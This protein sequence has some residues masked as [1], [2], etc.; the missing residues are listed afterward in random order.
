VAPRLIFFGI[1]GG[2]WHIIDPLIEGGELPNLRLLKQEGAW[3]T[4]RSLEP[5]ISPA[6]WT[7]I[8]SGKVPAKHGVKDFVV[9]AQSVRCKRFWEIAEEN[10]LSVG[11]LGYLV[12]WP[13]RPVR[14]FVIPGPFSQGPETHPPELSFIR[15]MDMSQQ[16][17]GA[18][19]L[20]YVSFAWQA[21][22]HGL[23]LSTLL[24]AFGVF[25]MDEFF[26]LPYLEVFYQ[27]RC[28]GLRIH[29]EVFTHLC[30]RY[31]PDVVIFV[32]SLTDSISHNFWKFLEAD[33]YGHQIPRFE[34]DRY[35]EKVYQAYR[36]VD[37]ALGRLL[38]LRN[39]N[40]Y[41]MVVSDHGFQ[42]VLDEH[43]EPVD[44]ILQI[45]PQMIMQALDLPPRVR[46]FSIRGRAYFRDRAEDDGI[47]NEVA[48]RIAGLKVKT[49]NQSLF[50][51][52]LRDSYVE[53]SLN[54]DIED[55]FAIN[56]QLPDGRVWRGGEFVRGI[57]EMISGVHHPD[58]IILLAGPGVESNKE[59]MSASVLDIAPTLLY[60]LRLP[61]GR[62]MDGR[63]LDE[64]FDRRF[65]LKHPVQYIETWEAEGIGYEEDTE[66][67]KEVVAERLRSLG[68]L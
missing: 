49:T 40:T 9:S 10:G 30:R 60:T 64:A 34:T 46:A 54:P 20:Q 68:Y 15:Q 2:T 56:V 38:A 1:D 66:E 28:V 65:L 31:D 41:V 59:I 43:S 24:E 47:R 39:E 63:F 6:I 37:R 42:S 51:V 11:M 45:R 27:K 21:L 53:V 52:D 35:K 19:W 50:L 16:S 3:G 25:V 8:A 5:L 14:G 23:R 29:V 12:T 62:D 13:P 33:R 26:D 58:G 57:G 17:G 4:L 32:A 67:L 36:E 18:R 55:Y 48:Q 7:S 61:V 44:R 22:R